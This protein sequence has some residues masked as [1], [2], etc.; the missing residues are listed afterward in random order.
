M[1]LQAQ[2]YD[3]HE[4]E[5]LKAFFE[6]ASAI[7]GKSNGEILEIK[8][9]N[10]PSS[11]SGI[12]WQ[13]G[14]T[15]IKATEIKWDREKNPSKIAG[16][17]DLSGFTALTTLDCSYN[18]ISS[19]NVS[20]NTALTNLK[21]GTNALTGLVLKSTSALTS[22]S[23]PNNQLP[24]LNLT[25]C[26]KLAGLLC[27]KNKIAQLDVSK[28][29]ELI[30]LFCA[31]NELSKLDLE[32]NT[33][34]K[35][36]Y[37][38]K[39][40]IS[41]LDVTKCE[42]LTFLNCADN[43]L[44]NLDVTK[45]IRLGFLICSN[46]QL[47]D[48]D[49]TI[50]PILK[51][52]YCNNNQLKKINTAHNASLQ[53]LFC[54][55]NLLTTL[56]V[57]KNEQLSSLDCSNNYIRMS[58]LPVVSSNNYFYKYSPQFLIFGSKSEK[59]YHLAG[60]ALID[61]S[62]EQTIRGIESSIIWKDDKHRE[63][64]PTI[65]SGWVFS[66]DDYPDKTKI[67]C[68]ITNPLFPD[69]KPLVSNKFIIDNETPEFVNQEFSV[70]INAAKTSYVGTLTAKDSEQK[71]LNYTIVSGNEENIFALNSST[72]EITVNKSLAS[73][74]EAGPRFVIKV[75]VSDGANTATANISIWITEAQIADQ[76]FSIPE[77]SPETSV[78]GVVKVNKPK[79]DA[80]HFE[81]MSGNDSGIFELNP[82]L[83]LIK[84]VSLLDY[85]TTPE[86]TFLVKITDGKVKSIIS[87]VI[88]VKDINEAPT[89]E[90][91]EF[92]M[93]ENIDNET[94]LKTLTATDPENK[95]LM[96]RIV[97]GNVN[98]AFA[99]IP[100]TGEL[101]VNNRPALDF[102]TTPEFELVVS[103]SDGVNISN[104]TLKIKLNDIKE[105]TSITKL[106]A[107]GIHIY[108]IPANDWINVKFDN[109]NIPFNRYEI[110]DFNGKQISVGQLVGSKTEIN[111]SG[112]REGFYFIQLL[113]KM[114]MET[115]KFSV[116]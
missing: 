25:E 78:V 62:T 23:C 65:N 114:H 57:E 22:L 82:T 43:Q 55:N 8:D 109:P 15:E 9:F 53:T 26:T 14:K 6:Q 33:K 38:N 112:M 106:A 54:H 24:S 1:S 91:L 107:Q 85:E 116:K 74:Y 21:C 27:N 70:A 105:V 79:S 71:V 61:L 80:L 115:I 108:P 89:I 20:G 90:D 76:E 30:R 77:N 16:H 84:I 66:F 97:D 37:C 72:G 48:L 36:V 88:N 100:H 94:V 63:I 2:S 3:Q 58:Q 35:A 19:L 4:V 86:H 87:V 40:W 69:F 11:W 12:V 39:N 50:N 104:A 64:K 102:E 60:D 95:D 103:V 47:V 113:G 59:G 5:K 83:G 28:N 92:S 32:N 67:Y 111:V 46:N 18:Q 51:R 45:N 99:I 110:I 31:L 49:I 7:E 44:A 13:D 41:Y 81:I 42:E 98:D 93:N 73:D 17:L 29:I 96:F 52:L 56:N 68:E 34:L 10:D 101:I 75:A